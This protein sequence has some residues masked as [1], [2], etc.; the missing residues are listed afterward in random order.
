MMTAPEPFVCPVCSADNDDPE[1]IAKG[2]CGRCHAWTGG[3]I[4]VDTTV[5]EATASSAGLATTTQKHN[6]PMTYDDTPNDPGR[7]LTNRQNTRSER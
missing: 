2:Y 3:R 4:A 5:A 6:L 7:V 1:D